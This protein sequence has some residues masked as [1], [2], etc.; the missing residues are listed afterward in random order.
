[1]SVGFRALAATLAILGLTHSSSIA[2]ESVCPKPLSGGGNLRSLPYHF[3]YRSWTWQISTGGQAFCNCV[4]NDGNAPK[5]YVEWEGVG[6]ASGLPPDEE[7]H[8]FQSFQSDV[9]TQD[10]KTIWFGTGLSPVKVLTLFPKLTQGSGM[11][12][13]PRVELIAADRKLYSDDTYP[14]NNMNDTNTTTNITGKIFIPTYPL[15]YDVKTKGQLINYLEKDAHLIPFFMKFSSRAHKDEKGNIDGVVVSCDYGIRGPPIADQG[16]TYSVR[17]S[18]SKVHEAVFA[19]SYPLPIRAWLGDQSFS[20]LIKN[21]NPNKS[22]SIGE[23][24]MEV[25]S[26]NGSGLVVGKI[27]ITFIDS[28]SK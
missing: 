16:A 2:Q 19:A 3:S 8:T 27:P 14:S 5:T 24:T 9:H 20:G 28:G 23:A 17:I 12:V 18:N 11:N 21:A 15:P 1:M 7:A 13:N 26:A 10:E 6:L 4:R 22:V 25:I